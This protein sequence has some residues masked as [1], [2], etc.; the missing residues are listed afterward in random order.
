VKTLIFLILVSLLAGAGYYVVKYPSAA[1]S[2]RLSVLFEGVAGKL[3]KAAPQLNLQQPMANTL[4]DCV[5]VLDPT[6]D[7]AIGNFRADA[8]RIPFGRAFQIQASSVN[9]QFPKGML[10]RL[11]IL[12]HGGHSPELLI[13]RSWF[14]A[15]PTI[16]LLKGGIRILTDKLDAD[17]VFPGHRIEMH[18]DD[19]VKILLSHIATGGFDFL[20]LEGH[21]HATIAK[22][23]IS[24]QLQEP[25]TIH[26][27]RGTVTEDGKLI[28]TPTK[29]SILIPSGLSSYDVPDAKSGA[30]P[31]GSTKP[32]ANGATKSAK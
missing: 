7:F 8:T 18:S 5:L 19:P 3:L 4:G 16:E 23:E 21:L 12:P 24:G 28:A 9:C 20:L 32:L 1:R 10:P 29:A 30:R 31:Q 22:Q 11:Q 17:F 26:T 13:R 15:P 14:Q 6:A 27:S 2:D 25:V